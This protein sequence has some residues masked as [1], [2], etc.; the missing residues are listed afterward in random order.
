MQW[1]LKE[2]LRENDKRDYNNLRDRGDNGW[3]ARD[4]SI[5]LGS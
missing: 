4:K 3:V 1:T 2:I 5:P